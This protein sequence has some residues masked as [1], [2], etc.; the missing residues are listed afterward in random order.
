MTP[1]TVPMTLMH[2]NV[3]DLRRLRA[4]VV[5]AEDLNFRRAAGRLHLSQPAL[6]RLIK[7]LEDQLGC[8]LLARTTR[9][10]ELTVAG[11]AFLPEA[12]P[13]VLHGDKAFAFAREAAKGQRG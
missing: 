11:R 2:A 7:V 12:R 3:P 10:V 8:Q 5:L 4:F 9:R 6:T 13:A 1:L